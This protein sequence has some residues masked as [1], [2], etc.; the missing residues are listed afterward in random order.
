[1]ELE[2]AVSEPEEIGVGYL[3]KQVLSR[4]ELRHRLRKT[5]VND[6]VPVK[7]RIFLSFFKLSAVPSDY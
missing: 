3:D 5:V 2:E 4:I 1:M 7:S 6:D